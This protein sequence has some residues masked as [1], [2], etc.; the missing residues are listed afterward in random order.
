VGKALFLLA[1]IYKKY[2]IIEQGEGYVKKLKE[3][4]KVRLSFIDDLDLLNI[5]IMEAKNRKKWN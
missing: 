4:I 3:P 1:N 2:T 5:A